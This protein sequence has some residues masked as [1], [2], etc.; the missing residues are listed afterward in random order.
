[1]TTV[2]SSDELT[3]VRA[4]TRALALLKAVSSEGSTLTDLATLTGIPRP[5]ALRL[6]RTMEAEGFV[7]RA[8]GLYVLGPAV[9]RL[10]V[11]PEP[12][13]AMLFLV[14]DALAGLRDALG[15]SCAYWVIAGARRICIATAE[16]PQAVRWQRQPG[17]EL[18]L[19]VGAG[20][21]VLMAFSD[22]EK[23]LAAVPTV[24]GKFTLTDGHTRSIDELRTEL[25]RIR[26]RGYAISRRE[27]TVGAWGAAVPVFVHGALAGTMTVIMPISRRYPVIDVIAACRTSVARLQEKAERMARLL[28]GPRP[29]RDDSVAASPAEVVSRHS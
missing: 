28:P 24:D 2:S 20:G 9:A 6:I 13:K 21:K 4:V 15:E 19:H 7:G 23:L 17:S 12:D 5:T 22:T 8:D 10:Q 11:T 26:Q 29:A 1:V 14:Q 27:S 25:D 16:S 18:K 3:G